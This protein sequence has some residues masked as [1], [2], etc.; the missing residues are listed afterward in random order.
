MH[1]SESCPP[2]PKIAIAPSEGSAKDQRLRTLVAETLTE[3]DG[4]YAFEWTPT[5]IGIVSWSPR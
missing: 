5:T 2:V 1:T 4:R 3:L